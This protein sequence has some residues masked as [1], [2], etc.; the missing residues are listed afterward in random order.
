[1]WTE[2][3]PL[4]VVVGRAINVAV[5]TENQTMYGGIGNLSGNIHQFLMMTTMDKGQT[6]EVI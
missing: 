6:V 1:M 3:S 4:F 2:I 5:S